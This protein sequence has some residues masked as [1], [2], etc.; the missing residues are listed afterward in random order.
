MYQII[1]WMWPCDE[2][3]VTL[4]VTWEKLPQPQLFKNLTRNDQKF[5]G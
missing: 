4:V 3:L 5:E 2:S 1:L